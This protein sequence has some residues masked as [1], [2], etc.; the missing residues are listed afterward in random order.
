MHLS[1]I[2][3]KIVRRVNL[4]ETPLYFLL[5]FVLF[6]SFLLYNKLVRIHSLSKLLSGKITKKFILKH[7][8]NFRNSDVLKYILFYNKG[9]IIPTLIFTIY[10]INTFRGACSPETPL[11]SFFIPLRLYI[12]LFLTIPLESITFILNLCP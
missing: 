9:R 4:L 10:F 3:F 2:I 8:M 11:L 7:L 5:F 12:K 1:Q 6:I